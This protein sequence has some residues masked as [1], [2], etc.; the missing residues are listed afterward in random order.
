MS[1]SI[2]SIGKHSM[3]FMVGIVLS[4]MT[5]FVMLPIY[6]RFL[7]P[8][9]YGVLELLQMTIDVVGM[10][11]GMSIASGIFRFHAEYDTEPER[12]QLLSTASFG[13]ITLAVA[14]GLA[15]M[16]ASPMLKSLILPHAGEVLHFRLF[17]AIYILQ[18]IEIVPLL[19][20]RSLN[21]SWAVVAIG[22]AKLVFMLGMNIYFVVHL[23]MAVTGVLISNLT[24]TLLFA[25]GTSAYMFA[26]V[27]IG[28][29]TAKFRELAVYGYPLAVVS[30]GN[31]FLVFSDRFF[32]NHYAS[33]ADVGIYSLA[34]KFAF[35]LSA[36]AFNPFMMAW[37][38][39]R[40]RIARQTDAREIF[41]RVF[42]YLNLV[43]GG[44][45]LL[46]ALF[47][48]DLLRIMADPAFHPAYRFIPI[49]LA[50]QVLHHWSAYNN[51]GL[52]IQKTT[53][54]FAWIS[55]VSIVIVLAL[56]WLLIPAFGIAGAAWATLIAYTA[57][58]LLINTYSQRA[59]RIDYDWPTLGRLYLILGT[60]LGFRITLDPESILA[61]I[62]M[63]AALMF[64]VILAVYRFVLSDR[65][66]LVVR[67]LPTRLRQPVALPAE[68]V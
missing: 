20:L 64:A 61:S 56:N 63:S 66:R 59:Y 48:R 1:Q 18:S 7:T 43:L 68:S 41:R 40:F 6:T 22:L 52:K 36:V 21:R 53:T 39:Q 51:L 35:I 15:G 10:I 25:L 57:R 58:F 46:I 29:S 44:M 24:A 8:S 55:L 33:T 62:A 47:S 49:V 65:E 13:L 34:F 16:A 54:T 28:F 32:L 27:G 30:V 42:L 60:A 17:F 31:F 50:A 45:A 11:A 12:N 2:S 37:G 19:Y 9:D 3:V 26:R 67:G 4:K 38:P 14:S 5:S 23:R